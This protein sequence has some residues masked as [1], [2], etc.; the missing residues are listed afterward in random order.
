MRYQLQ[1]T[2]I[3]QYAI[4]VILTKISLFNAMMHK[5]FPEYK[6]DMQTTL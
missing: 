4:S 6:K 3:N 1:L 5:Y 2:G